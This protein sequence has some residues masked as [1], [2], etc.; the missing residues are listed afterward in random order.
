M[1][2][3]RIKQGTTAKVRRIGESEWKPFKTTRDLGFDEHGIDDNGGTWTFQMDGWELKVSP[4]F[5]DGREPKKNKDKRR[6][7]GVFCTFK[8][9]G[10]SRRRNMRA[11]RSRR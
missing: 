3:F 8:G 7:P 4:C 9:K 6:I 2:I 10:A 11:N 1:A 5:V